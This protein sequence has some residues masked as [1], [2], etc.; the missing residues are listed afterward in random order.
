MLLLRRTEP[1][2]VGAFVP[3][4]GELPPQEAPRDAAIR[5][6]ADSI[7]PS[8]DAVCFR[9]VFTETSPAEFNWVNFVY[10]APTEAVDPVE[11]EEGVLEWVSDER[12]DEI[13][14]PPPDRDIYHRILD[15]ELFVFDA[16]YRESEEYVEL[17][18]LVDERTGDSV[19]WAE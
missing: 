11:T 17:T 3:F 1:P 10:T 12:I 4:G 14:T 13:Q 9:G 5:M 15:D 2:H 16:R 7:D 8:V 19:N 18:E 6:V